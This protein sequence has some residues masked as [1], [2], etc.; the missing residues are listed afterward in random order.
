[1]NKAVARLLPAGLA[2]ASALLLV[3]SLRLPL[4]QMRLEA[5]QYRDQEALHVAVHPAAMRGDLRE[6]SV[7]Q[8]YIGVH[9]PATL[10]QFKWLPAALVLAA[11]GGLLAG[12]LNGELRS[13]ALVGMGAAL[14]AA[15]AVAAAQANFQ[16]Y[17]IGHKRD[18]K[19]VL[20][21]VKDFTP[22]FVG[23]RKIAQFTVSSQFGAG[24]WFDWQRD[25]VAT[26]GRV[27]ES[28]DGAG[29]AR[30]QRRS[31]YPPKP[32]TGRPRPCLRGF[33]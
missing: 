2:A 11:A 13:R 18:G 23:T 29:T 33:L 4:W 24:A 21:G 19:T 22:P 31:V 17:D 9:I 12:L 25:G 28:R 8:Q 26:G 6:L 5:P 20:A 15:L 30:P 3:A 7:L 32:G 1:M 27:A 10:P 16:I 14:T